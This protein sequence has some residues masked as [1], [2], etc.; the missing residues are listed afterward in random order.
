MD[1]YACIYSPYLSYLLEKSRVV[2]QQDAERN[3][4]YFYQLVAAAADNPDLSREL[5][6]SDADEHY[7]ISQS[8]INVIEGVSDL[9]EFNEVQSA[10][11]VIYT[12]PPTLLCPPHSPPRHANLLYRFSGFLKKIRWQSTRLW[13]G[14]CS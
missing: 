13:L 5:S 10:M 14:S 7:Y 9:E 1:L 12:Y 4:H 6:L 8:S 3:Y 2:H 11:E